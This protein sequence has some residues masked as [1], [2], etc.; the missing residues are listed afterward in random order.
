M[1]KI[2]YVVYGAN[3]SANLKAV[4]TAGVIHITSESEGV[5]FDTATKTVQDYM[6]EN[7]PEGDTTIREY[8]TEMEKQDNITFIMPVPGAPEEGVEG[9]N[10]KTINLLG[11]IREYGV[12]KILHLQGQ[13]PIY[14]R[15]YGLSANIGVDEEVIK[16]IIE[17]QSDHFTNSLASDKK[18]YFPV[19]AEFAGNSIKITSPTFSQEVVQTVED[20]PWLSE[21]AQLKL[22]LIENVSGSDDDLDDEEDEDL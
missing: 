1:T 8:L 4:L 22:G 5:L 16:E 10:G 7:P 2:P 11:A 19:N 14:N 20:I 12:M 3:A 15:P 18:D 21:F 17:K 9:L 6:S 13:G